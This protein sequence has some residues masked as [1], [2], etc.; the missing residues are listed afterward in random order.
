MNIDNLPKIYTDGSCLQN[1][2]GPGGWAFTVIEDGRQWSMAG[3]N[4]STTNNRM[5]LQSIIE[6]L[7][8][9][10]G[11]EYVIY[12]DSELTM[13]C[14]NGTYNRKS[15]KDLWIEYEM[16]LAGRTIHW[17]WV[18]SHNGNEHNEYVDFLAREE[19]KKVKIK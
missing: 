11:S 8:F 7:L 16:A 18:K 9:V 14:A 6:A 19:A 4:P 2:N 15:N 1:P 13:K 3:N 12:T 17:C 5:E 10:Q